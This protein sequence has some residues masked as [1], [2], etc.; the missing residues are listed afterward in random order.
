[1]KKYLFLIIFSIVGSIQFVSAQTNSIS[2]SE[3]DTLLDNVAIEGSTWATITLIEYSDMECPFCIKLHNEIK[4]WK[5]V[6]KKY[7]NLVN[8]TFKN[9]RWVNHK[10]TEKKA[11]SLICI[12]KVSNDQAY[13]RFYNEVL[14]LSDY[15]YPY[16]IG[17]ILSFI[18]KQ[19]ISYTDFKKCIKDPNALQKLNN[20]TLEAEKYNLS[21]TPGVLIINTKTKQYL[22]VEWP[23][24]IDTFYEKI[25]E[26]L[27]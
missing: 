14:G 7:W 25:D 11:I 26:L 6:Q 10:N 2:Q 12:K 3:I 8:Y 4:L 13:I 20:E 22:T 5:N 1:M 16:P 18:R 21:G 15:G 27:K 19:N 17:R 9:N 24:P 23:Y